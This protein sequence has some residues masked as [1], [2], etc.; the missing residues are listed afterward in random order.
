MANTP[1]DSAAYCG[2]SVVSDG[3][4]FSVLLNIRQAGRVV[5]Q[6]FQAHFYSWRD[7][8]SEVIAVMVNNVESDSAATVYY[9]KVAPR[10]PVPCTYCC[11]KPVAA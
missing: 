2:F 11:C 3:R 5:M 9:Q 8:A 6:R 4:H 7:V 1:N 10:C